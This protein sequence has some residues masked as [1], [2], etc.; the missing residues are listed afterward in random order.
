MGWKRGEERGRGKSE[1]RGRGRRV[2]IPHSSRLS[3][4]EDLD[5]EMW[6][7]GCEDR[8]GQL[9]VVMRDGKRNRIM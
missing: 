3:E 7:H 9:F 4:W 6:G 1:R 2:R 8:E 5:M